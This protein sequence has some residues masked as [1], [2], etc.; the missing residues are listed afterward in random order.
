MNSPTP[1]QIQSK[2]SQEFAQAPS[3]D[4][5]RVSVVIPNYN[6][7]RFISEAIHSVLAQTY[8]SFEIIVVDDGSTDNCRE[9]VACFGNQVC[10]I[11]QENQGLAGARNTGIRA[12]R[13]ELIGLLDADDQWI[14]GYLETMVSLA[15][16][17]PKAAVYYC[18]AQGMD[19]DGHDLPQIFGGP[20]LSPEMMYPTLLRANYLI[21]STILIRRS[22]I[23]AAGLFDQK[24]RSCEDWDLWLRILPG[25]VIVGTSERLVR[26]RLH[27]S[28]LSTN[29]TGMQQATRAVIEKHFGPD[30]GQ[31]QSWSQEKRRA[32]GGVYRY[33]LLTS[34]Q[35]QNDWQAGA[36]YLRQALQ[37]DPT[38]AVDLELFY[39]LALGT[40]PP[41]YRGTSSELPI[42]TNAN[43]IIRMLAD[44]FYQPMT[45]E[46]ALLHYQT[47]GTACYALGLVAYNVGQLALS[48]KCLLRA[49][50]FRPDLWRDALVVGNLVKSVVGCTGLTWLRQLQKT[51]SR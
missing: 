36:R 19:V 24:L 18:C 10:Y 4:G 7:T 2:Q 31:Y 27:G 15:T 30:D 37:V 5:L 1:T 23:M 17:H 13:G 28:S 11:W 29:P 40:Q 51:P 44:V 22:V 38:L 20:V 34:I 6:H 21:P 32:Y 47:R 50:R 45:P 9:V 43:Q 39:D 16:Q 42:E 33:H 49:L 8:R 26:Y 3:P 35:R 48:R 12:A 14:P 25:K 46:L 41:G